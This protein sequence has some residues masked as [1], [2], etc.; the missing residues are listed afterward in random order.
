MVGIAYKQPIRPVVF[1]GA[2]IN[3]ENGVSQWGGPNTPGQQ[4]FVYHLQQ[5]FFVRKQPIHNEICLQATSYQTYFG[6]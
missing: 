1:L 3:G 2:I 4:F 5:A 6:W